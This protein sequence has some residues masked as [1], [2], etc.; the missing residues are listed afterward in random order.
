MLH[1][2]RFYAIKAPS[3]VLLWDTTAPSRAR[4]WGRA[5]HRHLWRLF[6]GFGSPTKLAYARG[7]RDVEVRIVGVNVKD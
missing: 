6:G 5:F 3:K 2:Q 1:K 7:W 4:A